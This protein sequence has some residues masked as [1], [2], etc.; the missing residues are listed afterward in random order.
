MSDY[1]ELVLS[2]TVGLW[3]Y[4]RLFLAVNDDSNLFMGND[5]YSYSNG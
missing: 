4:F 5:P 3:A 1:V 2:I